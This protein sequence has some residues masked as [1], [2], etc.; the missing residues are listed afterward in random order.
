MV[1][2][3]VSQMQNFE[4][5]AQLVCHAADFRKWGISN[6]VVNCIERRRLSHMNTFQESQPPIALMTFVGKHCAMARFI[7]ELS[8]IVCVEDCQK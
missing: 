2:G 4:P 1:C 7:A 5:K 3:L 8:F 6:Q